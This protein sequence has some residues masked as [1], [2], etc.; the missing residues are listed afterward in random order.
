[1]GYVP[2]LGS[3]APSS[4]G[5]YMNGG[6]G[7]GARYNNPGGGYVMGVCGGILTPPLSGGY[8][9]GPTPH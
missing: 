2:M 9:G 4:P 6:Y 3:Y 7:G 1:M 5:G 8:G